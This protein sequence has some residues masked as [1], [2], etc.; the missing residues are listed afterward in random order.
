MLL[1]SNISDFYP[2]FEALDLQG[3]RKQT[4]IYQSQ[5]INIWSEIV[6]EK[7]QAISSHS[8][9]ILDVMIDSGFPDLQIMN[10]LVTELVG[11]GSNTTT[12]TIEW[13]MIELLR[14]KGA[15]HKFQA[16]LTSNLRE[17]DIITESNI[18]ELP[19]LAAIVKETLRIHS[20]TPFLIPRR[21]AP[22][23]SYN[24]FVSPLVPE[25]AARG[26]TLSD[27]ATEESWALLPPITITLHVLRTL[28]HK[29]TVLTT[30]ETTS[31]A[32]TTNT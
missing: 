24:R 32:L 27:G 1:L 3:L 7:R 11:A 6:K 30:L 9:D 15:M 17:T 10:I 29:M 26:A 25:V 5:L 2:L 23:T 4:E 13:A 20:P 19:Y 21:A 8:S 28:P 16:E 14:N 22:E 12:S 31:R 18:S